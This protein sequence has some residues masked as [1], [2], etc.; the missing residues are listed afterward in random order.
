MFST[1]SAVNQISSCQYKNVS[2]LIDEDWHSNHWHSVVNGFH[3]AM[4]AA[5]GDEQHQLGV[6]QDGLVKKIRLRAAPVDILAK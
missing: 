2:Y 6:G 4:H 1:T 5:V 3:D